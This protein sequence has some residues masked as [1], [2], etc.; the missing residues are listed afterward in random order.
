MLP[1]TNLSLLLVASAALVLTPGQDNIYIVTRG[2]SQGRWAALVSAW[3]VCSGLLFHV[4]VAALGLSAILAQSAVAFTVVKYVGAAYLLYLGVR[5]ILS[6]ED[7]VPEADGGPG[8]TTRKIFFQGVISNVLNPKVA[9]FFLSFL[10]QFASAEGGALQLVFLG[11]IF[12]LVALLLTTVI[13]WFSGTL[14]QWFRSKRGFADALR[15][16]CGGILGGLGVRLVF[17]ER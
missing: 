11:C 17:L 9:L 10:P 12:A 5:T 2:I 6:R 7:F 3:G 4:A 13:A 8:A 15:W 1:D 16:A 14:G